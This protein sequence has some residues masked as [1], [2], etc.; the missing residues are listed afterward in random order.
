MIQGKYCTGEE[1]GAEDECQGWSGK[2]SNKEV[3]EQRLKG[4]RE[5]ESLP[6]RG[7]GTCQVPKEGADPMGCCGPQKV[8]FILVCVHFIFN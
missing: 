4:L 3:F 6:G 5:Q 8:A 2:A 1:W 7:N